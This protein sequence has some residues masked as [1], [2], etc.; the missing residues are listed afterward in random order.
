MTFGSFLNS[1]SVTAGYRLTDV[2][3]YQ[4]KYQELFNLN[5][6]FRVMDLNL[7]GKR[8]AEERGFADSYSVVMS[9]LGG[10]PYST[11]QF[12][13]RKN[14]V[15]DLR[16]NYRQSKYYW[17]RNDDAAQP[18]GLRGL[19]TNHDWATVRKIGSVALA[20]HATKSLRFTF[21][22]YRNTR[23]G[24]TWTTRSIDYF[25]ASS[26]W[27]GFARAN[28]YS[29]LAP[30]D[31]TANRL[32]GG[33]DYT[34]R[35]WN[36]HYSLGWQRFESQID[37]R[38]LNSPERSINVDDANTARELLSGLTY[39][40]YRK[41]TTPVSKFSYNGSVRT[42]LQARGGYMFYR[43]S[44]PATLAMSAN[45]L[46]RTATASV[47][48]PY[49]LT[50]TTNS[51]VTEPNHVIDQGFTFIAKEWWKVM[52]DYR[53]TRFS[54]D[55]DAEFRSVNGAVIA[56]GD[57]TN[58]WHVGTHRLDTNMVFTPT[59]SLLVRAGVRL[60]KSDIKSIEDGL[61]VPAR[62]KRV[63]S[64][65]P[66]LSVHYQPSKMVTLRGDIEEINT[67]T[68]YTRVTPHTDVGGRV[69]ARFRP[70]DKFYLENTSIARNRKLLAYDF[71]ST[72]RSNATTANYEFNEKLSVLAG[73][74]YDSFFASDFVSFLRG[75]APFTNLALRDQ[76][77]SR[78][79]QGGLRVSPVKAL[80]FNFTGNFV[81]T[82]GRGEIV[83]EPALY[84]PMTFP[85]ATA[86]LTYDV[87]SVG[88]MG[89]QL[90]RTY[91]KEEI[92][93]GNNFSANLLAVTWTRSF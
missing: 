9:G 67:G 48:S 36:L 21:D 81:R 39:A 61:I 1:G 34:V 2:N 52:T 20:V 68:P 10:E 46:A 82:T 49:A 60:M 45:G 57:S 23:S 79:W 72:I 15:Y 44:G 62:T 87:P 14:R 25:G 75:T 90:Q 74:S 51:R 63:K 32:T 76:T 85:Y 7:F 22:Y 66:I 73:F 43:Y 47:V 40:D 26:T 84:G 29:V 38:N 77:I 70:T 18:T 8:R 53:Y 86:V 27:G 64:V 5:S 91:Y 6:G 56:T 92:I 24:A 59:S 93:T 31:E 78:V 11:A 35:S 58:Q 83:G 28:P 69:M 16:V 89:L 65:W 13:M 37:G 19:S 42:R 80:N 88:R 17:N 41:L 33:V 50:L 30:V 71:R 12:T 55:S 54:V 3:G 4:P